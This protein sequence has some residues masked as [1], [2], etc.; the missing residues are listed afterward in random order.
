MGQRLMLVLTCVTA[1][2]VPVCA[3]PKLSNLVSSTLEFFE[4]HNDVSIEEFLG[5][6]RPLPIDVERTRIVAALPP[7]GDVPPHTRSDIGIDCGPPMRPGLEDCLQTIHRVLRLL[8]RH[9]EKVQVLDPNHVT[10]DLKVRLKH[11]DGF[12]IPGRRVVYLNERGEVFEH[13]VRRAGVWDYVLATVVWHEMAHIDGAQEAEA[14]R[15]EEDL[16]QQFVV[17]RKVDS[18]QGLTYLRLLRKRRK[19]V[20]GPATLTREPFSK[21]EFF[22]VVGYRYR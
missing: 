5:R 13:A 8:P 12:A 1:M 14:Q 22:P 2:F 4:G 10:P 3:S 15:L 7:H 19:G 21:T 16:W 9:P 20:A 17:M 6:L 18:G 11:V